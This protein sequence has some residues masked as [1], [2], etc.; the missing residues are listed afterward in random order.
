MKNG[1]SFREI[2]LDSSLAR[3][4]LWHSQ[5]SFEGCS[6]LVLP[7]LIRSGAVQG[8]KLV[9]ELFEPIQ[10]K[11]PKKD[12]AFWMQT[13]R[14]V[15]LTAT[16][17]PGLA[18][19]LMG[20]ALGWPLNYG[21][22]FLALLGVLCLQVAINVWNDVYDHMRLIDLPGTLGGSGIIQGGALN[23]KQLNLFA[24]SA[25]VVGVLSGVPILLVNPWFVLAIGVVAAL[26]V[27]GY[28]GPILNLKYRALGDATVFLLCGPLLTAGFSLASFGVFNSQILWLGGYFGFAAMGILHS[29]NLQDILVDRARG[30]RT[31]AN[32]LGFVR[33][34]YGMWFLYC[35]SW[36]SLGMVFLIGSTSW[37]PF[38]ATFLALPIA[39]KISRN[40]V[41][42]SGPESGLLGGIRI[43]TA[44]L[45]LLMG[46]LLCLGFLIQWALAR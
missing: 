37:I 8:D 41:M 11:Y 18:V 19:L 6:Y 13:V 30:A 17:T 33:A 22:F 21:F 29:N 10:F 35:S 3:D 5:A 9:V 46:V 7:R 16:L 39:F 14:A 20:L 42:A 27:L 1:D 12:F 40:A 24:W 25:F 44:Q 38:F 43:K 26:G 45:H 23:A 32:A 28:S 36:I 2:D 15:S 4:V 31:L 34:R